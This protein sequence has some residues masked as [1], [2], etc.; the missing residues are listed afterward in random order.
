MHTSQLCLQL[1]LIVL[2]RVKPIA[3]T[4]MVIPLLGDATLPNIPW[5]SGR[6]W[7]MPTHS[8]TLYSMGTDECTIVI[9]MKYNI[10]GA[11]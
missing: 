10:F 8:S 6:I 9:D 11:L 2:S 5:D 3:V 7:F 4:G 1:H